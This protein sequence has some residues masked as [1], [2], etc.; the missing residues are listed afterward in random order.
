MKIAL[1][2]LDAFA[3]QTPCEQNRRGDFIELQA[4][5]IHSAVNPTVLWKTAIRTL[6]YRQ[7]D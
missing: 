6:D 3:P 1:A 4:G 5:P 2:E 7:P